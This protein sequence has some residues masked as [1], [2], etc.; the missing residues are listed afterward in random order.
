MN[1]IKFFNN[2][3]I[4]LFLLLSLSIGM[5]AAKAGNQ[6]EDLSVEEFVARGKSEIDALRKQAEG[7][8]FWKEKAGFYK[9]MY[10]KAQ[11]YHKEGMDR[12]P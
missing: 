11:E 1:T 2:P 10:D 12:F 8:T 6:E 5:L 3:V 7:T 9:E 4:F